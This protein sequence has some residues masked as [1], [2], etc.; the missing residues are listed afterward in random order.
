ME[1][2]LFVWNSGRPSMAV[3]WGPATQDIPEMRFWQ[4]RAQKSWGWA[5]RDWEE[6]SSFEET[7]GKL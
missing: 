2:N 3:S 6:K 5:G 7:V 1:R 4:I